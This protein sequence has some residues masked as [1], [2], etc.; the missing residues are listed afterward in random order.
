MTRAVSSLSR[1][2]A[3]ATLAWLAV[4]CGS[5][6]K[7]IAPPSL[8]PDEAAQAA[9][10]EYDTNKDG[11]LDEKELERCPALKNLA[12]AKN[13]RVTAEDIA[14]RLRTWKESGIGLRG[15]IP[16][17]VELNGRPLAD[18]TVTLVPEAFLGDGFKPA[19]GS[20]DNTGYVPL[21][22]E[23]QPVPGPMWGFFKVKVSKKDGSGN[24]IIPA[25]YNADTILG[26]EVPP[27]G[28]LNDNDYV[29]KLTDK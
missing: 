8:S 16:V 28:S 15:G 26:C 12:R 2:I 9:M 25:R 10:A 20:S 1:V 5:Q 18:A 27:S 4:G 24:E 17:K 23:G 21:R 7:R 11:V 13:N 19:E 22:T 6:S 29:F 14:A 3:C